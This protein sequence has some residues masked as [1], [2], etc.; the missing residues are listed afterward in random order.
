MVR[1]ARQRQW[2]RALLF[3]SLLFASGCTGNAYM[4]IPLTGA[5]DPALRSLAARASAGDKQ[6]Q[7]ELGIAFE[8]GRGVPF[9]SGRAEKLY[10]L[11]ASD[12]GGKSWVYS[13]P[14]G[15]GSIGRVIPV[16]LGTPQTGLL[17]AK[18]RL[19]LLQSR[20]HRWGSSTG[21]EGD[22]GFRLAEHV[23]AA[24]I[25]I[26]RPKRDYL[27]KISEEP[28]HKSCGETYKCTYGRS[29]DVA[30]GTKVRVELLFT[31]KVSDGNDMACKL[32]SPRSTCSISALVF[33]TGNETY[34]HCVGMG[35]ILNA[36][37]SNGWRFSPI[38]HV[39]DD[40][41]FR[42][43]HVDD[44]STFMSIRHL[45]DERCIHNIYIGQISSTSDPVRK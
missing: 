38:R 3:V 18:Q 16:D 45:H 12:S 14:V 1:V 44:N 23:L 2:R 32:S 20:E 19:A 11:A 26:K 8:E 10:R 27:E 9:N 39:D 21:E 42:F 25:D 40:N 35:E 13:P 34:P 6:A 29:F 15:D 7:L 22:R 5:V 41:V 37:I 28:V 43:K 33:A 4:G 24:V 17:E 36:A 31:L 30:I